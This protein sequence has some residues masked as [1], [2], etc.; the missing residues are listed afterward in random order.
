MPGAT[1]EKAETLIDELWRHT[2]LLTDLRPPLTAAS[3]ARYVARRLEDI[4]AA[5]TAKDQ[6]LGLLTAMTAWDESS[7]DKAAPAYRELVRLSDKSGSSAAPP[8]VDMALPLEGRHI[9]RAVA[10]E[11]VRA[12]EVLLR[13]TP[14]ADGLP[15]LAAYRGAFEARYGHDREVPLLEL[16]DPDF[17]LGPPSAHWHGG[18]SG[19]DPRKAELR[20][21]A[22]NDL[23]VDALRGAPPSRRPRR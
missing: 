17:G 23:A 13:L 11:A 21:Q 22:L 3:P 19:L 5:S 2:L 7:W 8:Q 6:L 16:L 10:D 1:R 4:P 14:W 9:S 12:A 15:H 20:N 18:P